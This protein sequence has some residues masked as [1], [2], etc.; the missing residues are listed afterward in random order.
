ML[1]SHIVMTKRMSYGKIYR[2]DVHLVRMSARVCIYPTNTFLLA[3]GFLPSTPTVKKKHPRGRAYASTRT[4]ARPRGLVLFHLPAPHLPLDADRLRPR[5]CSRIYI[6]ILIFGSRLLE[7]R[8][9][10]CSVFNP[11]D[12]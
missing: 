1:G 3:D 5:G 4:Q 10:K 11:Q 7:K 8:G 12:P 6:H 9:K 2:Q